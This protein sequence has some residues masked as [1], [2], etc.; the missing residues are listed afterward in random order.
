MLHVEHRRVV[1]AVIF[2]E[3]IGRVQID[4]AG[5]AARGQHAFD[6]FHRHAVKCNVVEI[7]AVDTDV[8]RQPVHALDVVVVPAA[9]T[10]IDN[11]RV[12][13]LRHEPRRDIVVA[14]VFLQPRESTALAA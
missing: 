4:D 1:K 13:Q 5:M 8:L 11:R 6:P 14:D 9:D 10:A 3:L 7:D 12:L 2:V